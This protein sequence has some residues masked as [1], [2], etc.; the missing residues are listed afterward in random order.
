AAPDRD[1]R[2]AAA[3]HQRQHQRQPG[4]GADRDRLPLAGLCTGASD[5]GAVRSPAG[6]ERHTERVLGERGAVAQPQ[7][8]A[9]DDQLAAPPVRSRPFR[10]PARRDR[11]H[12]RRR[13]SPGL[14]ARVRLDPA[15]DHGA[16]SGAP[17]AAFTVYGATPQTDAAVV[18][19]RAGTEI[20]T[21][22]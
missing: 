19:V 7:P 14:A 4:A 18:S 8:G 16:L 1:P 20:A 6:L 13:S 21:A 11:S 9:A 2:P 12:A 10:R 22:S 15:A 17:F 3:H 5:T